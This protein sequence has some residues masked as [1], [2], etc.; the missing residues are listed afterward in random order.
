MKG[1]LFLTLF[2]VLLGA[3]VGTSANRVTPQECAIIRKNGTKMGIVYRGEDDDAAHITFSLYM[4]NVCA[5]HNDRWLDKKRI[6]TVIS[7]SPRWNTLPYEGNRSIQFYHYPI[8][9]Y[10]EDDEAIVITVRNLG[11]FIHTLIYEDRRG[12]VGVL[13]HSHDYICR[14][15]AIARWYAKYFPG[16]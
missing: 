7:I 15:S 3:L 4:G 13:L 10:S 6:T 14:H 12:H 1:T 16:D 9:E 2:L 5:A 11:I 8:D